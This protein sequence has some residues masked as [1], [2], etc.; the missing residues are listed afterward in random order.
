MARALRRRLGRALVRIS[1]RAEAF[2]IELASHTVVEAMDALYFEKCRRALALVAR[3]D[4]A[5][6]ARMRRDVATIAAVRAGGDVYQHATRTILVD[7]PSFVRGTAERNALLLVHEAT[8]A[9]LCAAGITYEAAIR[10]RVEAACVA[11]EA[12][13]LA[14]LPESPARHALAERMTGRLDEPWWSD[15]QMHERLRTRARAYEVPEWLI[16]WSE[17]RLRARQARG[18]L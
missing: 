3:H 7:W 17:R 2:G 8:H 15:E 6:L 18:D 9:R 10:P 14:R 13:F 5:R 16:R 12:A 4:P 1:P 11:Q